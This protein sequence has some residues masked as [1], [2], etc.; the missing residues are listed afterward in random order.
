MGQNAFVTRH[1]IQ[2]YA[3]GARL[4]YVTPSH[5]FPLGVV[6]ASNRRRELLA[7]ADHLKTLR[8]TI[9]AR[10]LLGLHEGL[11]ERTCA[12]DDAEDVHLADT[13]L[14]FA[15]PESSNYSRGG[16]H[17]EFGMA[18][19]WGKRVITMSPR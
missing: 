1:Q 9:T 13:L 10:W 14:F 8:F 19:A 3:A 11:P 6:R 2:R 5:Q 15:E 7:Y 17:V 4:V 12:L 18:V 16:R